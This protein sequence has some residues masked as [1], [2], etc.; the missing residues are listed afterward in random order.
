MGPF[1]EIV[2]RDIR[3]PVSMLDA[4]LVVAVIACVLVSQTTCANTTAPA[5]TPAVNSCRDVVVGDTV[6]PWSK[7][8]NDQLTTSYKDPKSQMTFSVDMCKTVTCTHSTGKAMP[9]GTSMTEFDWQPFS[10]DVR[11]TDKY[12]G[13]LQ[14]LRS[15][16][17]TGECAV[18]QSILHIYCHNYYHP[19][20]CAQCVETCKTT[21]DK[22]F[23][24]CSAKMPNYV[25]MPPSEPIDGNSS[26]VPNVRMPCEVDIGILAHCPGLSEKSVGPPR[27]GF[28]VEYL[29]VGQLDKMAKVVSNGTTTSY[30]VES[31]DKRPQMEM[32]VNQASAEFEVEVQRPASQEY[33]SLVAV[34]EDEAVVHSYLGSGLS[35]FGRLDAG[36]AKMTVLFDCLSAGSTKVTVAFQLTQKYQP[37]RFAFIKTCA[38]HTGFQGDTG[39]H[40]F[41]TFCLIVA[42][43]TLLVCCAGCAYK[44]KYK[45]ARG[46][47]MVPGIDMMRQAPDMMRGAVATVKDKAPASLSGGSKSVNFT[48][49]P[50]GSLPVNVVK[51][52]PQPE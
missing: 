6:Y 19:E 35:T 12:F 2:N 43:V 38:G 46:R 48:Y 24:I 10:T 20:D 49:S 25:T 40:G 37:I 29:G 32:D 8:P 51:S 7:V 47:E 13:F 39:G 9:L 3:C 52:S 33:V 28:H 27:H 11:E 4:R 17:G 22:C 31:D 41:R 15:S 36:P 16:N 21:M 44:Y 26:V 30:W 5:Q 45:G 23:C 14:T 34:A 1:Q 42:I 18:S 50:E